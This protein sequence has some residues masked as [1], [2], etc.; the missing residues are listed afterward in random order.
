[1]ELAPDR[2]SSASLQT[3]FRTNLIVDLYV[4]CCRQAHMISRMKKQLQSQAQINENNARTL[5]KALKAEADQKRDLVLQIV[6]LRKKEK[7]EE[8][9]HSCSMTCGCSFKPS[10]RFQPYSTATNVAP[11]A[12]YRAGRR[13]RTRRRRRRRKGEIRRYHKKE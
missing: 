11:A 5:Q 13:D 10:Q 7:G 2:D 9:E 4:M 1:M 8:Q 3:N 6:K 12:K